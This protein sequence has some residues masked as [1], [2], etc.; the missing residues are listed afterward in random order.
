MVHDSEECEALWVCPTISTIQLVQWVLLKT[1]KVQLAFRSCVEPHPTKSLSLQPNKGT[2]QTM[3]PLQQTN[4]R[5]AWT[6]R[7]P[8]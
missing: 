6:L 3:W 8:R 4:E 7:E 1:G 5:I 2:Q